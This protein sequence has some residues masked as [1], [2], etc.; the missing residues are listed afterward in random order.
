MTEQQQGSWNPEDF[1]EGG[2]FDDKDCTIVEAGVVEFDYQGKQDPVCAL[3]VSFRADEAD[4]D[5]KDRT[6]Y[7]KIGALSDFTPNAKK[8]QYVPTGT[9]RAMNKGGKAALFIRA[10]KDKGFQLSKLGGPDGVKALEGLHVHVNNVPMP[11]FKSKDGTES[12]DS[13]VLVITRI[14]D[15]P[16]AGG[17]KK[18]S[19]GASKKAASKPA[20]DSGAGSDEVSSRAEEVV[21]EVI[22]EKGGTVAKAQL[23]AAAFQKIPSSEGKVRNA[24]VGLISKED[25]LGDEARPWT[26][27][28]GELTLG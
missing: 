21:V 6:E 25:W 7:Y 16:A 12:K 1:T 3:M 17:G 26:Y 27:A 19:G 15:E 11:K 14:Y 20:A 8:T 2:F 9:K 28:G 18:Q 4:E 23:T 5:E 13:S 24:V 22:A 10:L